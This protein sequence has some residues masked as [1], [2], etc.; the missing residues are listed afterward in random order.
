LPHKISFLR[1]ARK[2][3]EWDGFNTFL[4]KHVQ[5]ELG[6]V[7]VRYEIL[8]REWVFGNCGG[9][10]KEIDSICQAFSEADDQAV[11]ARFLFTSAMW[12]SR[13][14]ESCANRVPTLERLRQLCAATLRLRPNHYRALSLLG[15]ANMRLYDSAGE[16]DIDSSVDAIVSFARCAVIESKLVFA[17][18]LQMTSRLFRSSPTV[19]SSRGF[20]LP[21][22]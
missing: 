9:A 4:D 16:T 17:A 8:R 7:E 6:S 22:Q 1:L 19:K 21:F 12:T 10:L 14:H 11:R 5:D 15:W 20:R 2:P 13:D 18:I 3:S